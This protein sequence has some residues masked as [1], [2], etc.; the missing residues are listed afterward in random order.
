MFNA[1]DPQLIVKNDEFALARAEAEYETAMN[2]IQNKDKRF[3]LELQT[4]D[5]EHQAIQTE[6][7]S[8]SKVMDKNIDRTFKIFG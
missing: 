1:N 5:T 8:V 4:I 7:D 6:M 2:E 3:D